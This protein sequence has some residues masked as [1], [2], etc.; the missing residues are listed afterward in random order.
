MQ[1]VADITLYVIRDGIIDK[2]YIYDLDRMYRNK[3]FKNLALLLNDVKVDSKRYGYGREY[4]E[5]GISMKRIARDMG[6]CVKTALEI[7]RWAVEQHL[8]E[9]EHCQKQKYVNG[10]GK[11]ACFLDGMT[12]FT[13]C[14][15]DNEYYILASHYSLTTK[16]ALSI[17]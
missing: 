14:T 9:R 3:T 12:D 13:F 10:I 8:I 4:H 16:T 5:F 7:V 15:K 2:R 17:G 11:L 6:V 1:R